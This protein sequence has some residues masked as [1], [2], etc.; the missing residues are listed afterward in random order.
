M[1]RTPADRKFKHD[2]T[3][4][5]V[6]LQSAVFGF[7][8]GGFGPAQPLLQS[9]QGTSGTIAG[10]HGTSLGLA[11]ILAGLLNAR[12]VHK[13]GRF[14]TSWIGIGIF[15]VG[16]MMFIVAPS[17]IISISASAI[18]GIG[19]SLTINSGFALLT[20][21]FKN[22]QTRA[23]SQANGVNSLFVV[24]G[25]LLI[26]ALAGTSINWRFG[27][28]LIFPAG[29]TLYIFAQKHHTDEHV[30][31][32]SGRQSGKLSGKYWVG[33]LAITL[34]IS[35]EFA[36]TFWSASLFRDRTDFS[37]ASATVAVLA[38]S[39]GMALGRW[40]GPLL[41]THI[42]LDQRLIFL[43]LFQLFGFTLFW[44]SHGAL[45][46]FVG[47]LISGLGISMQFTLNS[48]RLI[49]LSENRPDLAMGISALGA[50][51]AIAIAPLLLGFLA[52][53]I[54]ISKGYLM[55]PAIVTIAIVLVLATPTKELR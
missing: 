18:I 35:S 27:L 30:P 17:P 7:F 39:L 25:T 9:D 10:L 43:L 33:W 47:L 14:K 6:A 16:G 54:G 29:L 32:P 42:D 41:M 8:M 28:L 19:V 31:E 12:V 50:G 5:S 1:S 46:S 24:F 55:V 36:M 37:A 45:F 48:L 15:G 20:H 51:S 49:R 2:A 53:Q 44:F 22:D 3:F 23:A 26:G 34:C 52:D 13:F 21:H 4:W 11:S 40:F 38:G